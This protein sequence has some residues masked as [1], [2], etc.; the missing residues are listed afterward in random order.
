MKTEGVS[1]YHVDDLLIDIEQHQ[2][3]K[4]GKPVLLPEL[5]YKLLCKLCEQAPAAVDK[6]DIAISVWEHGAVSDETIAQRVRLLRKSI[7]DED[8]HVVVAVRGVGYRLASPTTISA[9]RGLRGPV[10][11]VDAYNAY[12]LGRHF[13][14][15]LNVSSLEKA[16]RYLQDAVSMEPE[17]AE[18]YCALG[19]AWCFLGSEYGN[20]PPAECFQKAKSA[21]LSAISLN[22]DS[23]EAHSL[24]ADIFCWYDWDF[25]AS[26]R[27]HRI[28]VSI[29]PK[30]CL[31]YALLLSAMNR[32]EEAIVLLE[33][34]LALHPEDGYLK[35]NLAWRYLEA[36][37]F[38]EILDLTRT[39]T[40]QADAPIIQSDALICLGKAEEAIEVLSSLADVNTPARLAL[41]TRAYAAAGRIEEGQEARIKLLSMRD[42]RFVSP[43]LLAVTAIALGEIDQGFD[44]L[45]QSYALRSRELVFLRNSTALAA[46]RADPRYKSLL[47]RVGFC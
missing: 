22:G 17:F 35:V 24:L 5:S 2:V 13:A 37:R 8:G 12:L 1:S 27:E 23:A 30:S 44:Y 47:G 16:I 42:N 31:G 33:N 14:F 32:S 40:D 18:A 41:L 38:D 36:G 43:Y 21:A 26:E 45:E 29:D 34:R 15:E 46:V 25:V 7:G 9:K 4:G 28:A 11:N 39:C 3:V 20:R 10:T 6:D 19:W